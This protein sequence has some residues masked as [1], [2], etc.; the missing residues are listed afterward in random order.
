MSG[1]LGTVARR[2]AIL[3]LIRRSRVGTQEE[4]KDRLAER[5]FRVTQ[6]TLSR[7]LARLGARRVTLRAGGTTY[8]IDSLLAEEEETLAYFRPLVTSVEESHA[9]VV[10]M[11]EPAAASTV[12]RAIDRERLPEV[13]ATL[14]GD[15][16]V[17]V[18]PQRRSSPHALARRLRETWKK[19]RP[20]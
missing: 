15:D 5:G 8:E 11:T 4:L 19:R 13:L 17:F 10:V 3:E 2:E 18:V 9:M 1:A 12:A 20:S 14:A 16:T 7:D 6:A